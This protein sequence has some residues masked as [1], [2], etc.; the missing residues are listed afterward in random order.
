MDTKNKFRALSEKN[1][2]IPTFGMNT[3]T[4][5]LKMRKLPASEF[6]KPAVAPSCL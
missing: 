1:S 6:D 4:Y 5:L 3:E 2:R